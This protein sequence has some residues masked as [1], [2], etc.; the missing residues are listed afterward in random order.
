MS[1]HKDKNKVNFVARRDKLSLGS[2]TSIGTLNILWFMC[3]LMPR[4]IQF[5]MTNTTMG[6]CDELANHL[7][8][9]E[10]N[11]VQVNLMAERSGQI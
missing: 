8:H 11:A 5:F 2:E 10:M 3:T 7:I 9:F 6:E 4:R 1:A